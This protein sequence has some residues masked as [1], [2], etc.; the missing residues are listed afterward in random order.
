MKSSKN[1]SS[2]QENLHENEELTQVKKRPTKD[3]I[4]RNV[5][6]I[7]LTLVFVLV[8]AGFV[9]KDKGNAID[10]EPARRDMI[11]PRQA[12]DNVPDIKGIAK[13]ILKDKS[14][15]NIVSELPA[16]EPVNEPV[17]HIQKGIPEE[18]V[19]TTSTPT[20]TAAQNAPCKLS[21][22]DEAA[23]SKMSNGY[24]SAILAHKIRGKII[25]GTDFSK[26]LDDMRNFD[27]Q[28][29]KSSVQALT[30]YNSKEKV[31]VK[32]IITALHDDAMNG[33]K[34][35]P[36]TGI[37][38]SITHF[39]THLWTVKKV[40]EV[41]LELTEHDVS[42]IIVQLLLDEWVEA[43]QITAVKYK[44]KSA[45]IAKVA[46]QLSP[47]VAAINECKLIQENAGM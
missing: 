4:G 31:A 30:D 18:N 17:N 14:Q 43:A 36:S 7:V 1:K 40:D 20:I 29:N 44:D 15:L 37:I 16:D 6:S 3:E 26:E 21:E 11:D 41:K 23:I 28:D 34:A 13:S 8:S 12:L 46:E 9:I 10:I 32:N 47:I 5:A 35:Q 27:M 2:K 38:D 33:N 22:A 45:S 39:F 24:H 42:S 19:S 25:Q